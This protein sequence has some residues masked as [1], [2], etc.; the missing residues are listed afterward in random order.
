MPREM[1]L[2]QSGFQLAQYARNV[3][4]AS[5]AEGQE[6]TDLLKPDYWAHVA[7]QLRPMDQ[8][9]VYPEDMSYYARLVVTETGVGAAR[10]VPIIMPVA[11]AREESE[12]LKKSVLDDYNVKWVS[13][14]RKYGVIRKSDG[15]R[16]RDGFADKESAMQWAAGHAKTLGVIA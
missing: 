10:V 8:I 6:F 7:S 12:E 14:S 9:D 2:I 13:P 5:P 1:K 11:L 3:W 16:V 4:L 15:E